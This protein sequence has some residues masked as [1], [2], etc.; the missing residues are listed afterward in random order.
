MLPGI[1]MS[2]NSISG[3]ES[4]HC[5]QAFVG[6]GGFVDFVVFEFQRHAD[7]AADVGMVFNDQDPF[8]HGCCGIGDV[9]FHFINS[10]ILN[11][12]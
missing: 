10:I 11:G 3:T 2:S 1:M 12:F 5:L 8:A 6:I 9:D 7:Q 4:A